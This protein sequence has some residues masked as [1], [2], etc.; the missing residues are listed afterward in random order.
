MSQPTRP[1][2]GYLLDRLCKQV[3]GISHAIAV[4]ADGL[5]IAKSER[6]ARDHA[7]QLSAFT[8]GMA[9]LTHGAASLMN[10]APVEQTVV[11]MHGGFVVVMAIGDGSVLTVLSTKDCDMGQVAYEMAMLINSVGSALTPAARQPEP[12]RV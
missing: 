12:E 6:L 8:S 5:L 7:D 2:W 11:E 3:R 10:A 1:N 4:S 9:S